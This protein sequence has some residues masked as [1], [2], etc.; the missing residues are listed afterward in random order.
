V[1]KNENQD[2]II[3]PTLRQLACVLL[4]ARFRIHTENTLRMLEDHIQQF[5]RLAS[6]STFC[7]IRS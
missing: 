2:A 5:G 1:N 6:V 7:F 4:L 3:I